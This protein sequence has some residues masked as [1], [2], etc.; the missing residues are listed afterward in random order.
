MDLP[1]S[2][3]NVIFNRALQFIFIVMIVTAVICFFNR[4]YAPVNIIKN[5][6]AVILMIGAAARAI[7]FIYGLF[8]GQVDLEKF[9]STFIWLSA[10]LFLWK[11]KPGGKNVAE[12]R[13]EE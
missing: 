13:A 5:I 10:G 12:E 9:A 6:I 1:A 11:W 2:V 3:D 4:R 8:D 7:Y